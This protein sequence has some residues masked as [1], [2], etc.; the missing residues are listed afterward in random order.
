M[1]ICLTPSIGFIGYGTIGETCEK[2]RIWEREKEKRRE[3]TSRAKRRFIW[4]VSSLLDRRWHPILAKCTAKP[5]SVN[6]S[7]CVQRTL[8]DFSNFSSAILSP[9]H[10]APLQPGDPVLFF[11][12]FHFF[13]PS[14]PFR[15]SPNFSAFLLLPT[16]AY[17]FH[18]H[19]LFLCPLPPLPLPSSR[20][21]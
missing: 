8:I 20:T 13:H 15:T 12:F 10:P 16:F 4:F 3:A 18:F 17:H 1:A 9:L 14:F 5:S 2:T 21:I 7:P 6:S 11:H 19:F